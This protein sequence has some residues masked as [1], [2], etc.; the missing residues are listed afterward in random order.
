MTTTATPTQSLPK[1]GNALHFRKT[2][3]NIVRVRPRYPVDTWTIEDAA[4]FWL[5]GYDYGK[6][7]PLPP[8]LIVA[9]AHRLVAANLYHHPRFHPFIKEASDTAVVKMT[10]K[11][12]WC[13]TTW[14]IVLQVMY[15]AYQWNDSA[16]P[17]I[18]PGCH[19]THADGSNALRWKKSSYCHRSS[20]K[21]QE[22]FIGGCVSEGA[23]ARLKESGQVVPW[24]SVNWGGFGCWFVPAREIVDE[25]YISIQRARSHVTERYITRDV[26]CG[27]RDFHELMPY[28]MLQLSAVESVVSNLR[29]YIEV[30]EGERLRYY[31]MVVHH[32]EC[33]NAMTFWD[34]AFTTHCWLFGMA[35]KVYANYDHPT[36]RLDWDKFSAVSQNQM[37]FCFPPIPKPT[38][39]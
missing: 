26:A 29:D 22:S 6:A 1:R 11:Y 16:Q 25:P 23:W 34:N 19:P 9:V 7:N 2:L 20:C 38:N 36:W 32:P 33:D 31:G 39:P 10:A 12:S 15:R 13:I 24:N 4:E 3:E 27:L 35:D 30:L 21:K 17:P 8:Q 37:S 28:Q 14:N 5:P 18:S